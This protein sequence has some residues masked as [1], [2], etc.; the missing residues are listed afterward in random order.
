MCC[1]LRWQKRRSAGTEGKAMD[2]RRARASIALIALVG[3]V[4]GGFGCTSE[5]EKGAPAEQTTERLSMEERPK[6][7]ASGFTNPAQGCALILSSDEFRVNPN[8][9]VLTEC[10]EDYGVT[11]EN[12]S[13]RF[14]QGVDEAIQ[15]GETSFGK[16][17]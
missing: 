14:Q 5:P 9:D 3:V 2:A 4:L 10:R 16:G 11:L 15:K 13:E 1:V 6:H 17:E 8:P 7:I 12:A